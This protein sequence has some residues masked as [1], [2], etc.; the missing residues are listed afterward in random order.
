MRLFAA[1]PLP[2]VAGES[3]AQHL[4]ALRA[5][6]WPVR[7]VR[8]G[9]LHVT[10]KFFG[11][12][13][14]DRLDTIAEML[15]FCV[16]GMHPMTLAVTGAGVFPHPRTP[17]VL[18]LDV[19]PV[20]ELELLQDR[21]ERGGEHIGFPPEGRPFHP[22]ITLGRVREGHRL[23]AAALTELARLEPQ[24]PFVAERMVLYESRLGTGGPDYLERAE[25][26]FG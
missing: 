13:T 17:R 5:L 24:P 26:R 18:R 7:W 4:R 25:F 6:D 1:V 16:D 14:P 11:E 15:G 3:A 2:D 8:E 23:P 20:P 10:L 21:I 22:H 12:V 19:T 9:G